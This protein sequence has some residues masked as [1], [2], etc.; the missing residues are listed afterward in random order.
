MVSLI[1]TVVPSLS[2]VVRT[3]VAP[4]S[5]PFEEHQLFVL[6][7][8]EHCQ[9]KRLRALLYAPVSAEGISPAVANQAIIRL[10]ALLKLC[11]SRAPVTSMPIRSQSVYK[12][13][14][15]SSPLLFEYLLNDSFR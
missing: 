13:S 5:P 15:D 4:A 10:T 14:G 12:V 9:D 3:T 7:G 11:Q 2:P 6:T 8:L 1:S